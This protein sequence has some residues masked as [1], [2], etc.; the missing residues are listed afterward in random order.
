MV[1]LRSHSKL[2][3]EQRLELKPRALS[4]WI[5]F[6]TL[7]RVHSDCAALVAKFFFNLRMHLDTVDTMVNKPWFQ[8]LCHPTEEPMRGNEA[9]RIKVEIRRNFLALQMRAGKRPS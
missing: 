5:L 1:C 7:A 6:S 4:S 2:A 9:R 8:F 3:A